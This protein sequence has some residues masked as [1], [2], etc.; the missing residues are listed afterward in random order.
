MYVEYKYD[1]LAER[2]LVSG[3][4][5]VSWSEVRGREVLQQHAVNLYEITSWQCDRPRCSG[6]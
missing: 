2:N 1:M 5:M 3:W 4:G 6:C